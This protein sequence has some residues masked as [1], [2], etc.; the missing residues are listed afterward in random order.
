MKAAV[1]SV[2]SVALAMSQRVG[3]GSVRDIDVQYLRIQE[4]HSAKDLD[5]KKVNGEFPLTF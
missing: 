1:Q 5:L 4:R 2:S 3:L